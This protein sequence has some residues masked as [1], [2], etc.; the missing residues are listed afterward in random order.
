MAFRGRLL[1]AVHISANTNPDNRNNTD[2]ELLYYCELDNYY[3]SWKLRGDNS[4]LYR[5]GEY[6]PYSR[7]SLDR[8]YIDCMEQPGTNFDVLREDKK[9]TFLV[10]K[11]QNKM[12]H[13]IA[14]KGIAIECNPTSNIRI[15]PFMQYENHPITK[16]NDYHLNLTSKTPQIMVSVNTDDLGVFNTSLSHEYALLL[17][18][19]RRQRHRNGN[20]ND[21]ELYDYLD[22]IRENGIRMSFAN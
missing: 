18:S 8:S 21:E 10:S 12:I 13:S 16:F 17:E 15:G 14:E 2:Y 5:T 20:Y 3:H 1:G 7:L 6:Q 22:Y 9:V 11:I 19:L 4:E